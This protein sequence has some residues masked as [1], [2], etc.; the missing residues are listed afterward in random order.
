MPYDLE[1]VKMVSGEAAEI[2]NMEAKMHRMNKENHYTP[3]IPF[4]GSVLE[5]FTEISQDTLFLLDAI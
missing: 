2:Y 5:C 1:V 4:G 3:K